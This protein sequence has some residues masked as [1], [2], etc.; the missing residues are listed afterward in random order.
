MVQPKFSDSLMKKDEIKG[1]NSFLE[2]TYYIRDVEFMFRIKMEI[3]IKIMALD[4]IFGSTFIIDLLNYNLKQILLDSLEIISINTD[5]TNSF[6]PL[7][8]LNLR[9]SSSSS[10]CTRLHS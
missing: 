3:P 6:M 7:H 4:Y 8:S 2:H 10:A 1:L 5:R 9:F